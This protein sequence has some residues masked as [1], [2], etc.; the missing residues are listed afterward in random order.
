MRQAVVLAGLLC[1]LPAS[2]GADE[3]LL[4]GGGRLSG[5]ILARSD[6]SVQVDVG[7]G[8]VTVSMASVLS[9]EEKRSSLHQYEE[10][11]AQL[12]DGDVPGWLQLARWSQQ[13]GLGTQARRAWE[14]VLAID[15][16]NVEANL[17]LGRV[18][19][20][21]RWV[22]EQEAN[23]ARGLVSFEGAWMTPAER[24]TIIRQRDDRFNELLRLD[25]ERRVRDAEMR[26]AEAEALAREATRQQS[27][28]GIPLWW[29]TGYAY[30]FYGSGRGHG[31]R[32]GP[33][34]SP[35]AANPWPPL[36]MYP[37]TPL[38]VY[39]SYP[40]GSWGSLPIGPAGS[41]PIGLSGSFPI[42]PSPPGRAGPAPGPSPP[43]RAPHA[44]P[45][46]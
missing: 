33:K 23:R 46:R 43:A 24:D 27:T 14:H 42:G 29:G 18:Q 25:A 2:A 10:R 20:D 28:A 11:V 8:I 45:R 4:K 3:V 30:P 32:R 41:F 1:C 22:T 19:L 7:P 5:R 44:R 6:T 9:I 39:P 12:A 40:I 13:Q 35:P 37:S 36:G 38:G 31:P 21:G 16:Q 34:S 15:A 17:A 26:A